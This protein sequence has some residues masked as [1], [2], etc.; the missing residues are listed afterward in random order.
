[1]KI[2]EIILLFKQMQ[3]FACEL[4]GNSKFKEVT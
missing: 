4:D 3:I 2:E 1:M